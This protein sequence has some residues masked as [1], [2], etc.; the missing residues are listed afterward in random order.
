[1]R[2]T[3]DEGAVRTPLDS[4]GKHTDVNLNATYQTE[5]IESENGAVVWLKEFKQF[6]E[7]HRALD[8]WEN[9]TYIG[10]ANIECTSKERGEKDLPR[11]T[12]MRRQADLDQRRIAERTLGLELHL[13]R[14]R[15]SLPDYQSVRRETGVYLET[16]RSRG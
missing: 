9:S 14:N 7:K 3:Y 15:S 12:W 11:T 4:P 6:I 8:A 10:Y 1:M 16:R 2:F 13:A 5:I